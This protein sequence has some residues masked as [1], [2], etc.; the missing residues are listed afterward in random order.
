MKRTRDAASNAPEPTFSHLNARGEAKMVDVSA[1]PVSARR[2]VA[3]GSVSVSAALAEMIASDRVP[4]GDLLATVRL[5]GI[6]AA[7]RTS[8]LIPLC[9]NVSLEHVEVQAWLEKREVCIRASVATTGKTGVEMEALTAVAVAALAVVDMGKS[10]DRA[11]V[12]GPIRLLEKTGG[13]HGPFEI[14]SDGL[15]SDRPSAE[16]ENPK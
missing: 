4:K 7:K 15:S 8:E 11:M 13:T 3:E 9:H 6:Q 14:P 2:A 1:K 16:G 12:I 5:A 10:I